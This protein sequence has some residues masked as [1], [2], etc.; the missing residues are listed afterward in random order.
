V[1]LRAGRFGDAIA[2]RPVSLERHADAH[3][4]AHSSSST[5][6]PGVADRNSSTAGSA[7]TGRPFPRRRTGIRTH[8]PKQGR[9]G[10]A[11][12]LPRERITNAR[13]NPQARRKV[14]VE[15]VKYLGSS[16]A[17]YRRNEAISRAEDTPSERLCAISKRG[18]GLKPSVK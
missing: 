18:S 1:D 13:V 12:T 7:R 10:F 5:D 8:R 17:R 2:K 6:K 9:Q 15:R 4:F 14:S 16:T 3:E 11:L